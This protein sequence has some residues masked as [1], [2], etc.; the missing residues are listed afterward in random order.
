MDTSTSR[1][2]SLRVSHLEG[3]LPEYGKSAPTLYIK[4]PLISTTTPSFI[5]LVRPQWNKLLTLGRYCEGKSS[6][7][8]TNYCTPRFE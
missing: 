4:L 5:L 6:V 1:L 3:E 7:S 8:P 2:A